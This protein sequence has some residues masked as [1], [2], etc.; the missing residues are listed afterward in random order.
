MLKFLK[1]YFS[2]IVI[3]FLI[4]IILLQKCGSGEPK[5]EPAKVDTTVK[6]IT[7]HD[8]VPGKT[9]FVKSKKDTLW[10]DSLIYVPDTS[11]PK[12]LSQY[13]K[14]GN[15]YFATNIYKTEFKI[16]KFGKGRVIDTLRS[17]KLVG[18][19]FEYDIVVPEKTITIIEPEAP[20]RHVY[21]GFG[22]YG[23]KQ[24]IV[25]GLYVGGIYKDKQ[26]RLTGVSVGYGSNQI[27]FGLS[28]YWKIKLK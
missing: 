11:Y 12:L 1:S 21:V 22:A 18:S 23:S 9:K 14:L 10:L 7:V 25:D 28:S 26:D 16:G 6:Y 13:L 20:K 3:I 17:N 19:G 5:Q 2:S 27:Q 4:F 15:K 8:T 24:N